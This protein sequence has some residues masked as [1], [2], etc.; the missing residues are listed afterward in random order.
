MGHRR[1]LSR[2]GELLLVAVIGGLVALAGAASVGKLGEKTVE[3]RTVSESAGQV[4]DVKGGTHLSIGDVYARAAPGVVQ[5]TSTSVLQVPSD[6]LFPD[7][8][9]PQQQEEQSLGSGFVIDKD[10]HIVT[11]YHVVQGAKTVKVSFS[12]NEQ[13]TAKVVGTDPSTDL[14]VLEV[15]V[16]RRALTPL[17][18]GDSSTVE[19]GDQV[20]AIGTPF[21]LTRTATAGIVSALGRPI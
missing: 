21:G 7:A 12:N 20:V 6:P 17:P 18:L 4:S 16:P 1:I 15:N 3:V 14:A 10:G 8:F 19:V 9:P 5:I 13:V 11:N 2:A